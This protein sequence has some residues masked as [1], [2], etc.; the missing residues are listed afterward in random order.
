MERIYKAILILM[1]IAGI[2]F[3]VVTFARVA[4]GADKKATNDFIS[5]Y[6]YTRTFLSPNSVKGEHFEKRLDKIEGAYED[7]CKK[8]MPH[9][10]T[11]CY[12][13]ILLESGG[14]P[15]SRTKDAYSREAGLTSIGYPQAT[16][17]CEEFEICG[18]PCG[19]PDWAVGAY[20][21]M[22]YRERRNLLEQHPYWSDWL[23]R[24]CD[25]SRTECEMFIT[26]NLDTNGGKAQKIISQAGTKHS[27]HVWY[28]TVSWM[29]QQSASALKKLF[30][31]MA[32][33]FRRY[34]LRWGLSVQKVKKRKDRLGEYS[35]GP[36]LAEP[37]HKPT[38]LYPM[39]KQSQW[40]KRCHK[41]KSE[42]WW[43][44]RPEL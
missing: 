40:R 23:P 29:R 11:E 9:D 21:W 24:L 28:N 30:G 19:D 16:S 13:R 35:W 12:V 2:I 10:T 6:D 4:D 39:P 44:T 15:W 37:P 7:E 41:W 33:S 27:K 20:A 5:G 22:V 8:Y 43:A 18:D 34:G 17:L 3:I 25:E 36:I 38:A 1:A 32:V 31:T 26:L 14:H 42:A